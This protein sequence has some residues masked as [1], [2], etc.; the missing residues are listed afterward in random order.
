VS[1][2]ETFLVASVLL[3][4]FYAV[5]QY[6]SLNAAKNVLL[7]HAARIKF[8]QESCEVLHGRLDAHWTYMQALNTRLD[9]HA[10]LIELANDKVD[11]WSDRVLDSLE[12]IRDMI[13]DQEEPTSDTV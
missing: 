8:M 10:G 6:L 7:L 4:A 13:P 1:N 2:T 12:N 11:D 5:R 9:T 3:L